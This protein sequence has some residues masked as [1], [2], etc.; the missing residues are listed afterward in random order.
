M[1]TLLNLL[2][3]LGNQQY[4]QFTKERK[5]KMNPKVQNIIS[6][7]TAGL[8]TGCI[9][10]APPVQ[11]THEYADDDKQRIAD[12]RQELHSPDQ[13]HSYFSHDDDFFSRDPFEKP[14]WAKSIEEKYENSSYDETITAAK[15][16]LSEAK[17]SLKT[18]DELGEKSGVDLS[19]AGNQVINA[20]RLVKLA[21][22]KNPTA[23]E[24]REVQQTILELSRE[25]PNQTKDSRKSQKRLEIDIV[26]NSRPGLT[27]TKFSVRSW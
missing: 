9:S 14:E 7:I 26:D 2:N 27:S 10:V 19:A 3:R 17:S 24:A 23:Q 25:Y 4:P 22:K 20:Y 16:L 11:V 8:S 21:R 5:M 12:K 1:Q 18:Y 13:D 6:A 15:E